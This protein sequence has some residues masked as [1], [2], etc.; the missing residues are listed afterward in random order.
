MGLWSALGPIHTSFLVLH[1]VAM[2]GTTSQPVLSPEGQVAQVLGP[3]VRVAFVFPPWLSNTS[4]APMSPSSGGWVLQNQR[5]N[6]RKLPRIQEVL[7]LSP[8]LVGPDP[9]LGNPRLPP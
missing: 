2:M 1:G 6:W 9:G 7:C 8:F 5:G 3:G 4:R